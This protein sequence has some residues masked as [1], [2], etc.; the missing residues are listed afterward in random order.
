MTTVKTSLSENQLPNGSKAPALLQLTNWIARPFDYLE[1]CTEKYGDMFTMRLFGLPPLVFIANPQ[2]IK[3]IFSADAK[4]F[5][6]G[7]TNDLARPILGN[8]SLIIMDGSRHKRERKLLMPPFRG[9]K[10]KA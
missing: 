3:E 4:S 6:V 2:G 9:E 7:R 8:N 10:V 1:E 5:D